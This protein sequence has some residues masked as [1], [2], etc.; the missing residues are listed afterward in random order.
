MRIL[1]LTLENLSLHK[2]S[3][4]HVKEIV[5]EI[6]DLGHQ[7]NLVA[8]SQNQFE[9]VEK[10]Y[11]LNCT[12]NFLLKLFGLKKQPYI[13]SSIFLFLYLLKIL[14]KYDVIYARDYH[15]VIIALLP[16]L[17]F[18]KKLVFEI[19]GLANEEQRLK[20]NW[21]WNYILA[22][23][24]KKA[25]NLATK[26]S[27]HIVS[28]TFNI[29]SYLITQFHCQPNKIE[30]VG[31]GVNTK[32]FRTVYDEISLKQWRKKLGI[33][34]G[35]IVIAFVGNLAPWQGVNVLI[36]SA[37]RLLNEDKNLKFLI[38]G[39]GLLKPLLVNKVLNSGYNEKFIFAG[40]VDYEDIPMLIN[41]ADICVAPFISKRNQDTGVS[42]LKVFEYMACGKPIIASRVEGLEFIEE[43]EV[44]YLVEPDDVISLEKA[45]SRLIKEP[46]E[47]TNMG[48]K[49]LQ[50]AREKFDWKLKVCKIE[51][52]LIKLA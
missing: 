47:R 22:F 40:M 3:V 42:P 10:F 26:C 43:E 32:L 7:V 35:E 46:Q 51:K 6:K 17:I 37:F 28:V 50:I 41:I 24:I 8:I 44:G 52:I 38:I 33:A 23:F 12:P 2:G 16:R 49:G 29:A 14:H 5:A 11:N 48:Q 39:D 9:K 30:V 15:T 34:K 36:E 18:K 4:V 31:N 27:D 45:L 19:N 25:E 1:Y 21:I 13:I 20:E